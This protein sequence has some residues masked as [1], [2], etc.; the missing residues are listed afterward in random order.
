MKW[1]LGN[2]DEARSGFGLR[3]LLPI[4]LPLPLPLPLPCSL[5]RVL[6]LVLVSLCIYLTV[7]LSVWLVLH[8]GYSVS[9]GRGMSCFFGLVLNG[10]MDGWMLR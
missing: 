6:V 4:P 1:E 2:W 9:R 3:K 8:C 5:V 10:W 7:Y